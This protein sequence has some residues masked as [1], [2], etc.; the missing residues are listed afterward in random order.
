VGERLGEG[1]SAEGKNFAI[2][3]PAMNKKQLKKTLRFSAPL[4]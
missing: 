3:R 2:P 1:S 4:R